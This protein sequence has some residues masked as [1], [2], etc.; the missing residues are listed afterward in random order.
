MFDFV[1]GLPMHALV[2][3][4]VV[5]FVPLSALCTVAYVAKASWRWVLRWPIVAGALVSGI[6]AFVAAESGERL[7][8][9]VSTTRASTTN[10]ELLANHTTWG[11]RARIVCLVFMLLALV[12]AYLMPPPLRPIPR[13]ESAPVGSPPLDE[14]TEA[15]RWLRAAEAP[16]LQ[17]PAVQATLGVVVVIVSLAALTVV[18]IAGHA[19]AQVVWAGLG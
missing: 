10:F 13:R 17:A 2:I 18:V 5:V 19:G 12:A 15:P 6:S 1:F 16:A 4:V 11:D 9:R 7:L 8:V 14:L 3:H